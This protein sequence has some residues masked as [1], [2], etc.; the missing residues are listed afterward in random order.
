MNQAPDWSKQSEKIPATSLCDCLGQSGAQFTDSVPPEIS[1]DI[2][3][4]Q[5]ICCAHIFF[6]EK[7]INYGATDGQ[8]FTKIFLV[9]NYYPIGLS[10]KFCKVPCTHDCTRAITARMVNVARR[11]KLF[12]FS[13]LCLQ[14]STLTQKNLGF[15][16]SAGSICSYRMRKNWVENFGIFF[17]SQI[18]YAFFDL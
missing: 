2:S 6:P 17:S 14:K 8:I 15:D 1:L 3:L 16:V 7:L 11:Q 18:F 12:L 9:V 4:C 13:L 5:K 10:F